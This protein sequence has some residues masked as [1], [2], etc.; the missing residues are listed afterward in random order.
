[1]VDVVCPLYRADGYIE[2]L[3]DG[4]KMQKGVSLGRV[5]FALTNTGDTAFVVD[6]IREAGFQYFNVEPH[7]FSHS[8]TREKAIREF[9]SS[10]IVI[11]LSQ[12]VGLID[13]HA[14]AT[15]AGAIDGDVVYAYGKQVCKKKT[16]EHYIRKRNYGEVSFSVG[17]EDI[18]RLQLRAF[19]ASDAFAAY[20]RPTFLAVNGYGANMMMNEDMFYARRV[21]EAG[22][23]TAY[24]S[25]AIVEHS[26]KFTLKQLYRRYF[27]MGV[28]FAQNPEF[29]QYHATDSGMKLAIYVFFQ[30]L[31]DFNVPVLFRWLPDMTARYFGMKRGRTARR[32]EEKGRS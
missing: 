25:E 13:E 17:K 30:A 15:L 27:A 28:W 1:M 29:Q 4:I 16:I 32:R 7:D 10:D 19:F 2:K 23:R 22:Y 5:V 18:E 6:K 21:L 14:M 26:H 11:M 20:H 3:I 24:V 12:D 31:K 8:F 9:C